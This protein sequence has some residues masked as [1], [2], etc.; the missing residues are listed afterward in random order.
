MNAVPRRPDEDAKAQTSGN[1][2]TTTGR[3]SALKVSAGE[4]EEGNLD[5]QF[6]TSSQGH[7]NER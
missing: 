1:L 3:D 2:L 7:F 5:S 6:E 4:G